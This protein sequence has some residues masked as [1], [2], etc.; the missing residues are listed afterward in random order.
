VV[1]PVLDVEDDAPALGVDHVPLVA[2]VE[3]AVLLHDRHDPLPHRLPA[4]HH[5]VPVL[6][7][8][9][10]LREEVAHASQSSPAAPVR[11]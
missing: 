3:L 9:D 6:E 5:A 8:V 7:V 2:G 4:A 11:Q 1:A 10:V